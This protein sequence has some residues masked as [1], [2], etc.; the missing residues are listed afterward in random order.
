MNSKHMM[1]FGVFL[2]LRLLFVWGQIVF[3]T[4][5]LVLPNFYPF[6]PSEG[7]QIV[8]QV[9]D[10]SSGEVQIS[11]P[12]PFFDQNHRALFVSRALLSLELFTVDKLINLT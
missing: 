11:I 9:D 2:A 8:Q 4:E 6:G 1:S 5:A 12:F 7:E 3:L 10:G